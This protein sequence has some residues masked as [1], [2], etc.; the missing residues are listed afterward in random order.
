LISCEGEVDSAFSNHNIPSNEE[1]KNKKY[2]KWHN[3]NSNSTDE[4]KVFH[5][6]IQLAIKHGKL[7][8]NKKPMKI[9]QYLFPAANVNMV[10][11]GE[12]KTK[13]LMSKRAKEPGSVD[14]KVQILADEVK[15]DDIMLI[16]K[17]DAR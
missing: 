1:L 2:C 10:E 8:E 9:D 17:T 13:L 15:D 11:F 4:R 6:Q 5:Q 14:P 16:R 12:G 7:E 3:S